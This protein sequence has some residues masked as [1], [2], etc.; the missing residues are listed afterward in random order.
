MVERVRELEG[1]RDDQSAPAPGPES[2]TSSG[3][4]RSDES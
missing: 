4:R 2:E 1:L 3:R